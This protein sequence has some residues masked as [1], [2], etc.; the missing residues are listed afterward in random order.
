MNAAT[1]LNRCAAGAAAHRS[2]TARP[3]PELTPMMPG[4]ASGLLSTV[5]ITAPETAS[6]APESSAARVRGSRLNSTIF[7]AVELPP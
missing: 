5:W 4:E 7:A 2:A 3:A 6:A 1:A